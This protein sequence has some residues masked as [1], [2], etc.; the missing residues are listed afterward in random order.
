MAK[1]KIDAVDDATTRETRRTRSAGRAEATEAPSRRQASPRKAVNTTKTTA[2]RSRAKGEASQARDKGKGKAVDEEPVPVTPSKPA[3]IRT[4]GRTPRR[5]LF[6]VENESRASSSKENQH[7]K[8]VITVTVQDTDEEGEETSD[9]ELRLQP[10]PLQPTSAAPQRSAGKPKPSA[11][12]PEIVITSPTKPK[13]RTRATKKA[14]PNVNPPRTRRSARATEEEVESEE[15]ENQL[16]AALLAIYETPKSKPKGRGKGKATPVTLRR[17]RSS[18]KLES[19]DEDDELPATPTRSSARKSTRSPTKPARIPSPLKP[20]TRK[21]KAQEEPEQAEPTP[22]AS[23][24]D[25]AASQEDED[26][27]MAS[28][29]KRQRKTTVPEPLP[30]TPSRRKRGAAPVASQSQ[31]SDDEAPA[32]SSLPTEE[33]EEAVFFSPVKKGARSGPASPTK[34]KGITLPPHLVPCLNAQKRAV[35]KALQKPPV[36]PC[37]DEPELDNAVAYK[38]LTDLLEGTMKRNEGNSCLLLGPRGSGKTRLVERCLSELDAKPIII[39]LSGWVQGSDRLALRQIAVQLNQQT[40]SNHF[41]DI[42][43]EDQPG[44]DED[45]N[46]FLD[47]QPTTTAATGGSSLPPSS[48]LPALIA[49]LPTLSRPTIVLVDA[50]DLFALHPRQAL[51]YCLLDTVQSCQSAKGNKG[52]AVIGLTTRVDT[53]QLLEKRVKSRFS[54]RILRVS[55]ARKE[56]QWMKILKSVYMAEIQLSAG[57][58]EGGIDEG[59]LEEWKGMWKEAVDKFMGDPGVIQVVNESTGITPPII[60]LSEN[61]PFPSVKNL[62]NAAIGQRSRPPYPFLS[63]LSYPSLCLLI[64]SH[65]SDVSGHPVFTFEMLYESF[66]RQLRLSTAAPIQL[67]GTSIGL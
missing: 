38:Q 9:D 60:H 24:N 10:Q 35:L 48:H 22:V 7:A 61:A 33:D 6:S 15:E 14:E 3:V 47:D 50:F 34:A 13:G 56:Y 28:P 62:T 18:N 46:P 17:T 26:V 57:T 59:D 36:I 53:L 58:G 19:D 27:V 55:A 2:T 51:L 30:K 25:E 42:N 52:L 16:E 8:P 20:S 31:D 4:Y 65:H 32:Q 5:N 12:K 66:K 41:V 1:R 39:R 43:G 44:D 63:D 45:V 49:M 40:G 23:E 21:R 29:S 54:G 64:A 11:A 37:D 67:H